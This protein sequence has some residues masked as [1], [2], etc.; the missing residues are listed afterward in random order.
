[1]DIGTGPAPLDPASLPSGTVLVV[2]HDGRSR[3][4]WSGWL[5]E[6]GLNVMMCPGPSFGSAMPSACPSCSLTEIADIVVMDLRGPQGGALLF[7]CPVQ[8]RQIAVLSGPHDP[9]RPLEDEHL[10]A[11]SPEVDRGELLD[12]AWQ[13]L[14]ESRFPEGE[15]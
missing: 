6:A 3:D 8:G 2:G 12:A 5:R 9:I 11:L 10:A 7:T 4:R 14:V 13:L 15:G 1:V